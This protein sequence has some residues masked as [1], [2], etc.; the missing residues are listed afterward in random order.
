MPPKK[1]SSESSKQPDTKRRKTATNPTSV[2]KSPKTAKSSESKTV[3]KVVLSLSQIRAG[4]DNPYG[5]WKG[6]EYFNSSKCSIEKEE[7]QKGKFLISGTCKGSTKTP[8]SVSITLPQT[9][10]K[11]GTWKGECNCDNSKNKKKVCSHQVALLVELHNQHRIK[12][13]EDSIKNVKKSKSFP[14]TKAEEMAIRKAKKAL[15]HLKVDQLKSLLRANNMGVT[16]NKLELQGRIAEAKVLGSVGK[17]T[18]CGGGRPSWDAHGFWVCKGYL[19]DVDWQDCHFISRTVQRVPWVKG[20]EEEEEAEEEAE[21]EE[22]EEQE[23]EEES[24]EDEEG[25]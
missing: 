21:E 11:V 17:C 20:E 14:T 8:Y 18:E 23:V 9:G 2:P 10:D 25:D 1:R 7:T 4:V 16:G 24:E 22:E 6:F 13:G 5:F 3:E 12:V 15:E 19:D